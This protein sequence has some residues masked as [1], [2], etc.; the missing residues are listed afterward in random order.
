MSPSK[1]VSPV[2][3]LA[4]PLF[5]SLDEDSKNIGNIVVFIASLQ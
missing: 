2:K 4:K 3:T 1:H 5:G